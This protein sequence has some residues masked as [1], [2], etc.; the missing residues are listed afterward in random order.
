MAGTLKLA[1]E[2]DRSGLDADH[3]LSHQDV[4]AVGREKVLLLELMVDLGFEAGDNGGSKT[5]DG[6][7]RGW[8]RVDDHDTVAGRK[9]G[10]EL[11]GDDV[12]G[13][14]G[15]DDNDVEHV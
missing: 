12:T 1:I 2:D 9:L 5:G 15:S 4:L 6:P 8:G 7:V 3:P 14:R 10:C 11:G 13:G